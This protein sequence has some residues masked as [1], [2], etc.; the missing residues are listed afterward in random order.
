MKL[1]LRMS[2][3]SDKWN[4]KLAAEIIKARLVTKYP[5]AGIVIGDTLYHSTSAKGVH[6]EP[7]PHSDNWLLIP[8]GNNDKEALTRYE[9]R[10]NRP[11]DY[12]SLT[13]FAGVKAS[14]SQR[15][16]CYELAYFMKTGR[17]ANGRVTVETLLML[18]LRDVYG[19]AIDLV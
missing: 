4:H 14:D 5:H 16:Y 1:A 17:L 6:S 7:F 2:P 12:V 3:D 9:Q 10:K 15:D 11:Y 18:A 8:Y 19:L 13:A